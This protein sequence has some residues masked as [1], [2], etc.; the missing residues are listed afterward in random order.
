MEAKRILVVARWPV[1]GIRTYFRYT[2]GQDCFKQYQ[3]T[4]LMPNL[5]NIKDYLTMIC[6]SPNTEFVE[7]GD[8][9]KNLFFGVRNHLSEETYDLIHSH[10]Y[11]AGVLTSLACQFA[12]VKEHL[13]TAHDVFLNTQFNGLTGVLKRF[14]MRLAFGKIPYIH[15]VSFDCR[16]NFIEFF[17]NVSKRTITVIEHGIDAQRFYESDMRNYGTE[18]D[19]EN[20]FLVG[21]FGRFMA[22]KGFKYLVD[23]V[24]QLVTKDPSLKSRLRVLTFGWG[25][26]VREEFE[27]ISERGLS[28]VFI[29]MPH[30]DDMPSA[31]KGLDVVVMPSLWEACGLLGME[32]L[33]AGVPIIGTS[34]IG[35]REVLSGSPA[36]V[37]EPRNSGDI[38]SFLLQEMK[39]SRKD[40][41]LDYSHTALA[42][43]SN[44]R[45]AQELYKLYAQLIG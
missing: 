21:F 4:F 1:G 17:P 34:C 32:V 11:S 8:S 44:K 2:Y 35:L 24:E 28:E 31:I 6:A 41:F 27:A 10:G 30:T 29:Q 20:K 42:R 19:V 37:A 18:L 33:V 15:A 43:F 3:I 36:Y 25:G 16:D 12:K 7:V 23:S 13:M 26:F 22:Q 14:S 38:A 45:S 40:L 5:G 39:H 9:G